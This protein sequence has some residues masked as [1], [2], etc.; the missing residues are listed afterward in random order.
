ML[1]QYVETHKSFAAEL[2]TAGCGALATDKLKLYVFTYKS[3]MR[4]TISMLIAKRTYQVCVALPVTFMDVT[5]HN[6]TWGMSI[7]PL[8]EVIGRHDHKFPC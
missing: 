2:Q 6:C 1:L 7:A 8:C 4:S 3:A 5:K